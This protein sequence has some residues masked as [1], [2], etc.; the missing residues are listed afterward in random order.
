VWGCVFLSGIF[1]L[2]LFFLPFLSLSP[3][4]YLFEKLFPFKNKK[5]QTF[6]YHSPPTPPPLLF[7]SSPPPLLFGKVGGAVESG[8][9]G[10]VWGCCCVEQWTLRC[11][12]T[13]GG[14]STLLW[15]L[16]LL[17][18]SVSLNTGKFF[19][20]PPTTSTLPR[21]TNQSFH[22]P[23]TFPP[24][25]F[26]IPHVWFSSNWDSFLQSFTLF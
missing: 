2:P 21:T 16:F 7:F 25:C 23:P 3:Q 15:V 13:V 10:E 24:L 5:P 14:N 11:R 20:K 18:T 22:L 12:K 8:K 19:S 26:I 6:L 9:S 4:A 17:Q 1:F